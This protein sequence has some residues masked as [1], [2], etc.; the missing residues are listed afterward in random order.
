MED[1][2][3]LSAAEARGDPVIPVF[4][5]APD[6]EG[7]WAPGGASRWW[8][9]HSLADLAKQLGGL[10]S[11]LVLRRGESRK[12]LAE[13]IRETGAAAVFWNRRYEPY[14]ID[15]DTQVKLALRASGVSAESFN[16]ALLFEPWEIAGSSG[17]PVRVFTA[18]WKRCLQAG[19]PLPLP[20]PGRLP[21]PPAWP[22]S[23]ELADLALEPVIDWA[24]GFR[25]VWRPGSGGAAARLDDFLEEALSAYPDGRNRPALEGVSRL[26]PH[27]HFGE[28]SPRRIWHDVE[29]QAALIDGPGA[30]RAGEAFLRQLIW[31]EF[32]H[33]LLFHFPHTAE[34]PLRE[35]FAGFPWRDDA[36]SVNAWRRG[37]TGYPLVDAGMRQ[38]W[39]TG[40]MHNR[41]RLVAASFLVKHLLIPWQ[42]GAEWFWDTLVD[43]DLANNTLGWQWTAGTGADAAPY[44]RIFNPVLQGEKL[45]PEGVY[46]R[47][48]LPELER[49]P[50]R[51]IHRPWEAPRSVLE[52]A[53]VTI[54]TTYPAPIIDHAAA[55]SRALGAFERVRGYSASPVAARA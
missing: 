29:R 36:R 4:I 15:R 21:G 54:G 10:G 11:R 28:I 26:S 35:E 6:E 46:V 52:E 5:W 27:L 19:V 12:V 34:R 7:A 25:P 20:V 55:R 32:A 3:A 37:L 8:L 53:G 1:N 40:W 24:A 50:W 48:W 41:V 16:S 22:A 45:D 33:H 17:R 42:R 49:L 13:L 44:F 31:R 51:W 14:A 39:Q 23:L 2:P 43:A 18:F 30:I 9:H 47:R 38:L